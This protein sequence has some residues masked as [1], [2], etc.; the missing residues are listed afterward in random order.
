MLEFD[1]YCTENVG[2][3]HRSLSFWVSNICTF[4]VS[5]HLNRDIGKHPAPST[6]R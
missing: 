3:F 5:V 1:G 2:Y 6:A 4:C